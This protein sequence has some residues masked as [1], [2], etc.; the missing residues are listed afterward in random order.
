MT[1][2]I[3]NAHSVEMLRRVIG[4]WK[5]TDVSTQHIEFIIRLHGAITDKI[6]IF[7]RIDP[8]QGRDLE[9]D[10]EYTRFYATGE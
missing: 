7:W 9:T 1:Y 6:M 10:N 3:I 5:G 8:L 4:W 2:T